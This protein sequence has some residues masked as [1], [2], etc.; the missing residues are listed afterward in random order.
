MLPEVHATPLPAARNETPPPAARGVSGQREH[1]MYEGFI[2]CSA[3]CI[4]HKGKN[5]MDILTDF[6]VSSLAD[7]M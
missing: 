4:S 5:V 1:F 7:V 3:D 6:R 2:L